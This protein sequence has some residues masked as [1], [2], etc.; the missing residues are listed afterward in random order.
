MDRRVYL[1]G[2]R[3]PT[4]RRISFIEDITTRL[5]VGSIYVGIILALNDRDLIKSKNE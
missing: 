4:E 1:R 2:M 3:E 5:L